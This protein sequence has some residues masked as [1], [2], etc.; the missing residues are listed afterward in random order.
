MVNLKTRFFHPEIKKLL[1]QLNKSKNIYEKT[2]KELQEKKE[3]LK[4]ETKTQQHHI[5]MFTENH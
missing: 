2:K 3:N 4:K 1:K 5:Q